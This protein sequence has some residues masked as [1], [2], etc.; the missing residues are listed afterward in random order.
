VPVTRERKQELV[1]S[2]RQ[3]MSGSNG[4]I[5]TNY[6]GMSVRGLDDLRRRVREAG[7]E[8][9]VVKNRLMALA[10]RQAGVEIPAEALEG[11]T[12]VG[13]AGE[14]VPAVAKAIVDVTR[15]VETLR[16][17][18]GVL[19][20]RVYDARQVERLAELPPLPIVRARLLG[21]LQTPAGRVAG[22]VAGSVRQVVNVVKAYSETQPA[23]A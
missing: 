13:F 5:L 17:K 20:G 16:L 12:A 15:Q 2:Y 11:P 3:W 18:L 9:H 8:L 19:E 23:G 1:D 14:D 21:L 4:L 7:G 22:V 10:L 6:T